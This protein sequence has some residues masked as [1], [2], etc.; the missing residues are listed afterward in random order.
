MVLGLFAVVIGELDYCMLQTFDAQRASLLWP[1]VVTGSTLTG[2]GTLLLV[3]A[4]L[5]WVGGSR[6]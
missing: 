6:G 5:A 1:T 2:V 3:I 4:R